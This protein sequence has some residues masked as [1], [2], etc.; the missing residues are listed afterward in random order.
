MLG[1]YIESDLIGLEAGTNTFVYVINNPIA[2]TDM[3]GL[4]SD[5]CNL[6]GIIDEIVANFV[7]TNDFIGWNKLFGTLSIGGQ[8][9]SQY[10]GLMTGQT[11]MQA[12]NALRDPI[13]TIV[14]GPGSRSWRAVVATVGGTTLINAVLVNGM[15]QSGNLAGSTLGALNGR[16]SNCLAKLTC[17]KK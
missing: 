14:S 12:W 3:A 2:R 17:R 5:D 9:A 15:F 13:S 6:D 1:R 11:A 16:L 7:N 4:D 10:G 8:F